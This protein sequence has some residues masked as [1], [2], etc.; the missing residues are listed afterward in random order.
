[1]TV[2]GEF[3][4]HVRHWQRDQLGGL[5]VFQL[6]RRDDDGVLL[7]APAG[8]R[9][10]LFNMP[11]GRGLAETPLREWS[12]TRR[13]PVATSLGRDVLSWHP[14]GRDYSIRWLFRP[15]GTFSG[16]YGNLEAPAV[17]TGD[18]LDTV[19]WDLDVVIQPDRSWAWK[20]EDVFAA[21]LAEPPGTYW[22]DDE[23]RVRK[24]GREVIALAESGGFPFDGTWCDFRP[25]PAWPALPDDFPHV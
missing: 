9:G 3:V 11:D 16:W 10:W 22:V 1:M 6:V 18:V 12:S 5:F 19:D 7:W 25:D 21:R 20:D 17:L 24:A 13:V 23:E 15:D 4:V 14:A 2:H 8:T